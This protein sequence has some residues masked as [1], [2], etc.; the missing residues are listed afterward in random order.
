MVAGS[1][2]FKNDVD[3]AEFMPD[4]GSEE[5]LCDP[6][7]LPKGHTLGQTPSVMRGIHRNVMNNCCRDHC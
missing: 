4:T 6:H 1:V 2:S 3:D 5:I 7:F